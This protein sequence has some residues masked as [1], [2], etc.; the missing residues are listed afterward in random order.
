MNFEDFPSLMIFSR[1]STTAVLRPPVVN[2]PAKISLA[3]ILGDVDKPAGAGET[4]VEQA[5]IDVAAAIDLGHAEAGQI[6]AAAVVKIEHLVLV[7]DGFGIDRRAEIE[8]ALRNP[9]D[10]AGLGRQGHKVEQL[11]F[12]GNRGDAFGHADTRD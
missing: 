9:A 2:V 10:D 12:R 7:D 1:P 5:D 6:Q 8:A 11:F 4:A 3:R